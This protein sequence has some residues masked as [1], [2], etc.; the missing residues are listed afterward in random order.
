MDNEKNEKYAFL[1]RLQSDCE[2]FLGNGRGYEGH[3]YY[4]SV[5][6]Q[7]DEMEKLWNSFGEDK[8]PEWITIEQIKITGSECQR[9]GGMNKWKSITIK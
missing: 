9:K 4:G 3:L 6:R 7:C 8:K 1:S 5:D 2:Y